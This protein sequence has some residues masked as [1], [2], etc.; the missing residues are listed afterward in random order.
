VKG[1]EEGNNNNNNEEGT[2]FPNAITPSVPDG[3]MPGQL[4]TQ[5]ESAQPMTGI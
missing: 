5:T 4:P 1:A 3:R 2:V